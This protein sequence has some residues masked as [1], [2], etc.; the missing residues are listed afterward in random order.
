M[1]SKTKPTAT[2]EEATP[3]LVPKL[4]FPE[5]RGADEWTPH[6]LRQLTTHILDGDW[7][8]SKDQA[9]SGIRLIQTGNIGVGV[10]IA[11]SGK[12]RY[13]TEDTFN[14][15]RCTEVFPGDCLISRLPDPAGRSCF[16]PDIGQRM[17]TAV[18][19]TIARFDRTKIVPEL[20]LAYSQTDG[21]FRE[22][23]ALSS[24]STRQRVSRENLSNI[25][26]ALPNLAEQQKIAECLSSVDELMAAQ[27]RKVDA[28]KTHKKGLMQQLFPREGESQPR[29]RFPEFQNAGE[30][31]E[32]ELGSKTKKVGSGITPTGG[33]KTYK[34]SGRPFVRSQNVGWGVLLL[35]D[36]AFIDE[37]THS[38]FSGT[39]L[40]VLDVLLNITGASIGRSAIADDRIAGGNVN[41]HVCIIRVK[42][43]E[44][45]PFYLNQFLI[46]PGGQ[47][48]IDSFQA[49][50]NRQGLNF[51]QIRSF[52]LPLP[53]KPAEQ[54]RIADCL[55]SLDALITAETQKLEALKIHKRGLMQ[56]LFPSP[57]EVE[58]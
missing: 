53:P 1:S 3:A 58:A 43:A 39:E 24:G 18:D 51:A 8:E 37:E 47:K 19:C 28:L 9:D 57:E 21:Y 22:I 42:S 31:V 30:W 16:L 52:S 14:R 44:L 12:S 5:F 20:F 54:Q 35:D 17:I 4:R 10:F 6:S 40:Q 46:S 38:S 48:Q 11:K 25:V 33:D 41:Q 45:N 7:I 23:E 34:L 2:K 15:L 32:E 49:G 50:G 36:V 55:T 27:A 13:V 29:L 56:Q 26:L